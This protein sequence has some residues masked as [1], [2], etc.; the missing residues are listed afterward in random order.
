MPI[1]EYS[2]QLIW[3]YAVDLRKRFS[4]RPWCP[5]ELKQHVIGNDTLARR[6]CYLQ[7]ETERRDGRL[8][9]ETQRSRLMRFWCIF[10]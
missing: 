1:L 5:V 10:V 7:A 6:N 2:M 9:E 3:D 8:I 4:A